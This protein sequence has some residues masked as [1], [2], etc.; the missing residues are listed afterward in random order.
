VKINI[1]TFLFVTL[2][3][4][5]LSKCDLRFV[6]TM[7]RHGAR[8]P[9]A[10]DKNK[11]DAFGENWPNPGELT[12]VGKRM[13]F[14]LGARNRQVYKD[15][16]TK[17]KIDG[18]VYIRSTDYNR[19]MESVQ[20]QMQGF[21]PP[22][23]ASPIK[24]IR[25]RALAH[26]FI[27]DPNK[28][29]W[30]SADKMLKMNSIIQRV[31]TFPV[32]LFEEPNHLYSFFYNPNICKIYPKMG[33]ENRAQP[34]FKSFFDK[35]KKNFG[36]QLMKMTGKNNTDFLDNYW[37]VFGL[38]DSFISD[39]YDGRPLESAL[40]AG[41]NLKSFNQTAFEFAELD[42]LHNWSGDKDGFFARWTTSMLW[43]EVI[44]WME[45][46]IAADTAGE[47][48]T[49]YKTPRFAVFSTHDVTVGS[50]LTMLNMAFGF[51][52]YYTPFA[53]DIFFELHRSEV[54]KKYTVHVKY[55]SLTLGLVPFDE[56]K[57]KLEALFYTHEQ[58]AEKC[59]FVLE[60]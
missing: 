47:G 33:A 55:Q 57:T 36:P 16:T 58:I 32:H 43:P 9:T 45:R 3:C 39:V 5:H 46:R 41:I 52:K 29:G 44:S 51:K 30:K 53:S 19:T 38:M 18:S 56:F 15:F 40:K 28:S 27:D 11:N 20:S 6:F 26:P 50:G 8:S 13:H 2:L 25:A 35:L 17:S 42:I 1:V 4:V 60:K 49:G 59:G 12:E 54:D 37:Y 31:E 21:F 23:T 22:G 7:F 34:M 48:Y 24:N 14:L 10:L